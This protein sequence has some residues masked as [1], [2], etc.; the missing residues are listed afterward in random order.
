MFTDKESVCIQ[1]QKHSQ[2]NTKTTTDGP[3]LNKTKRKLYNS[4]SS[5]RQ[6]DRINHLF[7]DRRVRAVTHQRANQG[8]TL[9][10]VYRNL[11]F[12]MIQQ[13]TTRRR[14]DYAARPLHLQWPIQPSKERVT[15][16]KKQPLSH[17]QNYFWS[18]H[19]QRLR[20]QENP[21]GGSWSWQTSL[22]PLL[23]VGRSFVAHKGDQPSSLWDK[24]GSV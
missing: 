16:R 15:L 22:A 10:H 11:K 21:L 2:H 4:G 14:R 13:Q 7:Q 12:Q 9:Q 20:H 24:G 23:P 3:F 5:P 17:S 6:N 18:V 1:S 19:S 8:V